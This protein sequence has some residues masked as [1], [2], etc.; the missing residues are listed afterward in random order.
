LI[1]I[2]SYVKTRGA[3]I[4]SLPPPDG[5]LVPI[6]QFAGPLE[7]DRY[8]DGAL[9][10]SVDQVEVLTTSQWDLVDHLWCDIVDMLSELDRVGRAHTYFPDQPLELEFEHVDKSRVR[11][12]LTRRENDHRSAELDRWEFEAAICRAGIHF[13]REMLRLAP[14]HDLYSR[15]LADLAGRAAGDKPGPGRGLGP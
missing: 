13:F 7:D 8:V 10:I 9:V 2:E 11:I 4:S 14:G 12:T 6:A 5:V 3:V 15:Y 1:Q